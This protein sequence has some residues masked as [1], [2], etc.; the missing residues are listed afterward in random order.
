M[1]AAEVI[2][3][4]TIC[5]N[6][7]CGGYFFGQLTGQTI[8]KAGYFWPTL[9]KDVHAYVRKCDACQRYVRNDLH[10]E[11]PLHVLLLLTYFEKWGLITS[12]KYTLIL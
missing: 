9:F 8:L 12:T 1:S 5:H 6:S 3:I 10:M 2:P 4:L 11:L 7:V